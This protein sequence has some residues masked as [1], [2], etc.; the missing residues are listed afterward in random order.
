[1][2]GQNAFAFNGTAFVPENRSLTASIS[3]FS[4][5]PTRTGVTRVYTLQSGSAATQVWQGFPPTPTAPTYTNVRTGTFPNLANS[6]RVNWTA[7]TSTITSSFDVFVKIGAGSYSLAGNVGP[8]L[9]TFTY[10][11]IP[12][13]TTYSF[14]VRAN[15]ISGLNSTGPESSTSLSGAPAASS[16]FRET[17]TSPSSITWTWDF[18]AGTFQ[19]FYVYRGGTYNAEVL[20]TESATSATHTWSGLSENSSY[21]L[22]VQGQNYDGF[23]SPII[24]D[25]AS[26][27]NAAPSTPGVGVAKV[28]VASSPVVRTS[29]SSTQTRSFTVTVT[30]AAD[31]LFAEIYLEVSSDGVNWSALT[32]WTDNTNQK[33]Y[34]HSIATTSAITR[35]YKVRQRDN[36][37]LY[38]EYS[39]SVSATSDAVWSSTEY[40]GEGPA[41]GS[42][43]ETNYY[44][45]YDSD[46]G[47]NLSVSSWA[48]T[49]TF[50][51]DVLTYGGDQAFDS[52]LSKAWRS[53]S[54]T[55][56]R[57]RIEFSNPGNWVN[58]LSA[59]R[60]RT[61]A[62]YTYYLQVGY[63]SGGSE[64]W[65]NGSS[66]VN[67]P[68]TSSPYV[69]TG[70]TTAVSMT[71]I[72]INPDRMIVDGAVAGA[73]SYTWLMRF[74][75]TAGT[76]R[77]F[78]VNE[79]TPKMRRQN[80][81]TDPT[82]ITWYW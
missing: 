62:A 56:A 77:T 82:Y 1:M 52:D 16:N 9:R 10:G 37:D 29:T 45:G 72:D 21:T 69:E 4:P 36:Q 46:N 60:I 80:Y 68:G 57:I 64:V 18:P 59:V 67:A 2:P 76:A 25:A 15:G 13:N 50:N 35:H 41:Y 81:D 63:I 19:R 6:I 3:A 11:N 70:T 54:V 51:D 78:E 38:S 26:T 40:A 31:P 7:E 5:A 55:N 66:G 65:F 24:A 17:S 44:Y 8:S 47:Q 28:G 34:T 23:W 22:S 27:T 58:G 33:F 20:P 32:S 49:S 79:I 42:G 30:P 48:V 61:A 71:T 53:K 12:A 39:P 14:Y 75:F 73:N 43:T 74:V